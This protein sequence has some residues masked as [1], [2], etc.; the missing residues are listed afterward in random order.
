MSWNV[1]SDLF[2][3]LGVDAG[4]VA[5]GIRSLGAAVVGLQE[6]Q[7]SQIAADVAAQLGAPWDYR[8]IATGTG[9]GLALL[10]RY[11][12]VSSRDFG[13]LPGT[14]PRDGAGLHRV[15]IDVEGRRINVYNT[16]LAKKRSIGQQAAFVATT[17]QQTAGGGADAVVLGDFE[18]V[19]WAGAV[20]RLTAAGYTDL[21]AEKRPE[22]AD[23]AACEDLPGGG[24]VAECGYTFSSRYNQAQDGFEP[25]DPQR[26][27]ERLD[28]V[29]ARLRADFEFVDAFAPLADLSRDDRDALAH[30]SDHFPAVGVLRLL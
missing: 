13:P 25:G 5:D 29:L 22:A 30:V 15:T 3:P 1:A 8:W 17:V 11:P 20:D 10:S 19:P 23:Q 7:T 2:A 9:Q 28:Y 21:W 26:P 4:D 16:R 27:T 12:I 6:V 24:F 14:Q 18:R